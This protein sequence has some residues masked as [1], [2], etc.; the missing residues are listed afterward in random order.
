MIILG[1]HCVAILLAKMPIWA[2]FSQS[3]CTSSFYINLWSWSMISYVFY[4]S[5]SLH[6][7]LENAI[8]EHL[9]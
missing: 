2:P 5:F 1:H 3:M 4:S 9:E 7:S 6:D 8:S